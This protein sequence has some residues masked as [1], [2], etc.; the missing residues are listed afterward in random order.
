MH[1]TGRQTGSS[2]CSVCTLT[3]MTPVLVV[4]HPNK[5]IGWQNFESLNFVIRHTPMP[6]RPADDANVETAI[7]AAGINGAPDLSPLD[8]R[9]PGVSPYADTPDSISMTPQ[10]RILYSLFT[11]NVREEAHGD[12][13]HCTRDMSSCNMDGN[14]TDSWRQWSKQPSKGHSLKTCVVRFVP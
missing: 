3:N 1:G 10:D 9:I 7:Q 11:Y 5:A 6:K 13:S 4:S 2:T 14:G 12:G 8:L